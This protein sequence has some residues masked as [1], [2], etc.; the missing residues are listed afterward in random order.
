[1]PHV[2]ALTIVTGASRGLG[3]ALVGQCLQ[4]GHTVIG[5][6]RTSQPALDELAERTGAV[7]HQWRFDLSEPEQAGW[8]LLEWLQAQ[9]VDRYPAVNLINNAGYMAPLLPL[10]AQAPEETARALRVGLEAAMVLT[11][12]FLRG[13]QNWSG[14]RKVLNISSGLGQRPMASG[15]AYCAAKAGLDHFSR[16]VALEEAGQANGARIVSLAPGVIDTDMQV[17]LRE[18]NPADFPDQPS[19]ARLHAHS[20]L[21]HP[22]DAARCILA[23]LNRADF[24]HAVVADVRKP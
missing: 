9:P 17:Q 14:S 24:G 15:A 19:F 12:L 5:I 16:C 22:D 3:A 7:L 2:S 6:A 13:T 8:P 20:Q 23:W 10:S 11:G 1:M 18:A 21:L 4:Q